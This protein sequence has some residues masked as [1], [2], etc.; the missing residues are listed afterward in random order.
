MLL[1]AVSG[2][3]TAS[4]AM[5]AIEAVQGFVRRASQTLSASHTSSKI[6]SEVASTWDSQVFS[7]PVCMTSWLHDS[8]SVKIEYCFD[9]RMWYALPP[10]M[11]AVGAVQGLVR[12]ASSL[13]TSQ[14]LS[15]VDA[16]ETSA[17]ASW[18]EEEDPRTHIR[19][20]VE[21]AFKSGASLARV[22]E[23]C[24]GTLC[25]WQMIMRA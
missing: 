7:A 23:V 2:G 3:I 5:Q 8:G 6:D 17:S 15:K 24:T 10:A 14:P 22:E 1:R 11:Q 4:C 12:R 25:S 16:G 13:L 9:E 21:M 19:Q 18:F 20:D